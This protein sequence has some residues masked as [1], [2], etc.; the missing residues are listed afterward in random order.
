MMGHARRRL[1]SIGAALS[2]AGAAAVPPPTPALARTGA[3]LSTAQLANYSRD[4]FVLV[5][6]VFTH[7]ECDAFVA[8]ALACKREQAAWLEQH[9]PD[10]EPFRPR[11]QDGGHTVDPS[12]GM[13]LHPS[14]RKPLSQCMAVDGW[15][16]TEPVAIQSMY[17]WQGS[18]QRRHQDQFY[19]PECMSSWTALEDVEPRNGTVWAQRGS[20][21]G[22]LI[23]KG[24]LQRAGG[25]FHQVD[26][27]D[28]VDAVWEANRAQG[29]DEVPIV[30]QKGDVLFFHGVRTRYCPCRAALCCPVVAP[31]SRW[32]MLAAL[33]APGCGRGARGRTSRCWCTGGGRS[34]RW[35]FH[36]GTG[37]H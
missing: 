23:T 28:A 14:Y 26:Y 3:G 11:R 32:L 33:T 15:P 5:R 1:R 30:A 2:G 10:G 19:L 34:S 8:H 21:R 25:E 17:F 12:L 9:G 16:G 7:A 18:E 37:P 6:E 4:G 20:H 13:L 24:D 27:N 31:T 36:L 35:E 22:R 29:M